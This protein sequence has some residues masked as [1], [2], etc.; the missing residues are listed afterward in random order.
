[1]VT[2]SK[3]PKWRPSAQISDFISFFKKN[4]K[5]LK[6]ITNMNFQ[7]QTTQFVKGKQ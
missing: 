6:I 7:R 4:L 3:N 1:M 5:Q 2:T